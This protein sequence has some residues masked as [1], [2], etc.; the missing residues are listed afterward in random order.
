MGKKVAIFCF[1]I[2]LF[3]CLGLFN[4]T[5]CYAMASENIYVVSDEN[6]KVVFE[7]NEVSVGD[8]YISK[9][10]LKYEVVRVDDEN[11]VG[12]AKFVEQVEKPS[13]R[14]Y[15]G[16]KK[17]NNIS[18]NICLYL[19]HNDESYLTGDGVDSVYGK[20]GIHDVAKKI[21][22]ELNKHNIDVILDET[23]HIP[24][25]ASAYSRSRLTSKRL[26]EDYEPDA[27]F[28]IHRDGASRKSY[29]NNVNGSDKC[30][31]RMVVGLGNSN[32]KINEEFA[33]YIMGVANE[34]YPWL[35]KDIYF[36][37]GHYN[38]NLYGKSILFEMGSHLVEKDLV[39]KSVAPLCDVINTALFET[40]VNEESGELTINGSENSE[41]TLI[42]NV[43][44]LNKKGG[45]GEIIQ[46]VMI[47]VVIVGLIVGAFVIN[48][49]I[50]KK[51]CEK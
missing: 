10:F 34:M 32:N 17:I 27:I 9:D 14:T 24:H 28:D 36:G 45:D 37:K 38:Q 47:V 46:A 1:C 25:D 20:G 50:D 12:I 43:E 6:G 11:K 8:I 18:K 22:S 30:M 39:M 31:V 3:C 21:K 41:E 15:Y 44:T 33:T 48:F 29:V 13:V 7:R 40:T 26:L 23:L 35:I 16:P 19:T 49:Y 51:T 4:E 2:L 42:T 5:I